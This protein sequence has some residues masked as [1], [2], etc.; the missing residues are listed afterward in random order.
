[1]QG[2]GKSI[3][4]GVDLLDLVALM[5]KQ[6]SSSVS[7]EPIWVDAGAGFSEH[8]ASHPFFTKELS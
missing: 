7:W 2:V 3:R 8:I 6:K 4:S 1:M 5:Q